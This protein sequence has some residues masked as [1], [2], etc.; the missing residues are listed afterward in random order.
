[1]TDNTEY[2][3]KS[4][5]RDNK[6]ESENRAR[7]LCSI[8]ADDIAPRPPH[9][10]IFSKNRRPALLRRIVTLVSSVVFMFCVVM[11]AYTFYD[12]YQAQKV[13]DDL[14]DYMFNSD[15]Q[16]NVSSD[17]VID[18]AA[19]IALSSP[20][21][22]SEPCRTADEMRSFRLSGASS[23]TENS[24]TSQYVAL[25]RAK[26]SSLKAGNP[27]VVGYISVPGTKISYPIMHT[28]NN[29][30]Y[31]DH[32]YTGAYRLSGAI[33]LDYRDYPEIAINENSCIYGHNLTN[34]NMMN[35]IMLFL[36]E[37]FFAENEYVE[38]ITETGLYTYR[39]FAVYKTDMYSDYITTHFDSPEAVVEFAKAQQERSM[40]RRDGIEFEVGNT[41]LLTLST[42]TNVIQ[43]ERYT[44]QA[45]LV[46]HQD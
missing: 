8:T 40:Y 16:D 14:N 9:E 30:Y 15:S 45:V 37:T 39:I 32:D 4:R 20:S 29:E 26:I 44:L 10:S 23:D 21:G 28:D 17:S 7:A 19:V 5:L 41:K 46:G 13:Y 2:T 31:L 33:F 22:E 24:E 27:D 38:V 25:M 43:E 11:L 18:G 34:G 3:G 12:R 36:D 35:N 42:C 1:M 6:N